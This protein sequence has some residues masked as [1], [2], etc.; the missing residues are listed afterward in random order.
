M[1]ESTRQL[2]LHQQI[3][4]ITRSDLLSIDGRP[5]KVLS[6]DDP[7]RTRDCSKSPVQIKQLAG[8]CFV[9]SIT[10]RRKCLKKRS[11][12][13]QP[14]WATLFLKN[15]WRKKSNLETISKRREVKRE[16]KKSDRLARRRRRHWRPPSLHCLTWLPSRTSSRRKIKNK[17]T[18]CHFD[19]EI[20]GGRIYILSSSN[21]IFSFFFFY[22][23][24]LFLY[25]YVVS[26][27]WV[28]CV[29]AAHLPVVPLHTPPT[30]LALPGP[31]I[32]LHRPFCCF[33]P[34]FI[35][36]DGRA[37]KL[38]I[39]PPAGWLLYKSHDYYMASTSL[40]HGRIMYCSSAI[41]IE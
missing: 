27:Y 18:F 20:A 40:R 38:C 13:D 1:I 39:L 2:L 19:W 24:L 16:R 5:P 8:S 31:C 32:S 25:A 29:S 15:V 6:H 26:F 35:F 7:S 22:F 10:N 4:V 28:L 21:R 34:I 11:K 23:S 12:A 3:M 41:S 33:S 17:K 36:S 14:N 37:K 9:H 30:L